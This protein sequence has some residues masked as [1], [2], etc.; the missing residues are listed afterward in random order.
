MTHAKSTWDLKPGICNFRHLIVNLSRLKFKVLFKEI[1]G[2]NLFNKLKQYEGSGFHFQ[3]KD[4]ILVKV[5]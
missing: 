1:A 2:K 3:I 4:Y 5:I